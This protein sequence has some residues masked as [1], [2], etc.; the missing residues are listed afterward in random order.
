MIRVRSPQLSTSAS[1]TERVDLSLRIETPENV[2]LTYQ[3]AGPSIRLSA[4]LIDVAV[5]LLLVGIV[6][7]VSIPMSFALP[8]LTLGTFLL[9]LFLL[10]WGYFA[11]C[12]GFFNGKTIGKHVLGLRVIQLRGHPVSF[13]GALI[14]NLLRAADAMPFLLYGVGFIS[15]LLTRHFQRLGDLVAQT[16]VITERRVVFPHEP[17]IMETIQPLPADDIGSFVPGDRTLS[18]IDQF[19]GRRSVLSHERG[20]ELASEL[21]IGLAERLT[22]RGDDKLVRRYPMAFLARVYVTFR[23]Q[24]EDQEAAMASSNTPDRRNSTRERGR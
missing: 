16:V 13:W 20:H 23:Q 11:I 8:G 12:E 9:F 14:R 17:V 7:A 24:Q 22:F 3:L 1:I 15:M 4:Y 10:E 19:L 18:A 21:A 5:R 2:V 6:I